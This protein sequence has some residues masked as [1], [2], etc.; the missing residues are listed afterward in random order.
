M[1]CSMHLRLSRR[2][3]LLFGPPGIMN[4]SVQLHSPCCLWCWHDWCL[5]PKIWTPHASWENGLVN[6]VGYFFQFLQELSHFL[7]ICFFWSFQQMLFSIPWILR[8]F[9]TRGTLPCRE[10]SGRS[11]SRRIHASLRASRWRRKSS[12]FLGTLLVTSGSLGLAK[13]IQKW[14]K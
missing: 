14:P 4:C 10:Y 12:G 8:L 9:P 1:R 5:N 6:R 13:S 2:E 3:V 11:W 7:K